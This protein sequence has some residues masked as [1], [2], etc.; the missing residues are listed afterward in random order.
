LSRHQRGI[1]AASTWHCRGI[2]AASS[3]HQRSVNNSA[4]HTIPIALMTDQHYHHSHHYCAS[5]STPNSPA[6]NISTTTKT[7]H[8]H[9]IVAMTA[10]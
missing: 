5:Q 6:D 3:R 1:V 9:S 7:R 8:R 2:I 4:Q 10:Q